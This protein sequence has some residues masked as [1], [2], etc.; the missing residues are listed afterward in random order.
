MRLIKGASSRFLLRAS[1]KGSSRRSAFA[2]MRAFTHH[3]CYGLS[4]GPRVLLSAS[5][6]QAFRVHAVQVPGLRGLF[7]KLRLTRKGEEGS[8]LFFG[9]SVITV[10]KNPNTPKPFLFFSVTVLFFF[11]LWRV[12]SSG[13]RC[14]RR[15]SR[16]CCRV[17]VLVP[18]FWVV[19]SF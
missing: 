8:L 9:T 4:R 16:S 13:G 1:L 6:F 15:W 18:L 14:W 3:R 11:S 5:G 7:L 19:S 17:V 10:Q 12:A 2:M